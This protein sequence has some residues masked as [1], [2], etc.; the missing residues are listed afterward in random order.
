MLNWSEHRGFHSC[1][2]TNNTS[3]TCNDF[4]HSTLVSFFFLKFSCIKKV[5][6]ICMTFPCE[7][8]V[9]E[10]AHKQALIPEWQAARTC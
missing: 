6:P 10:R 9:T 8:A 3:T 4:T 7:A 5:K 1:K 2:Y